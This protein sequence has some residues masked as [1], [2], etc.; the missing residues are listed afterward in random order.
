M[1]KTI[2]IPCIN[3]GVIDLYK[4]RPGLLG[5]W[6]RLRYVLSGELSKGMM[7]PATIVNSF[8][9]RITNMPK[10]ANFDIVNVTTSMEPIEVK[11]GLPPI[12][13]KKKEHE[14]N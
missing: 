13:I 3:S 8:T 12:P 2:E 4:A 10:G 11:H 1:D 6:D 5:V 9:F 7:Q 14:S